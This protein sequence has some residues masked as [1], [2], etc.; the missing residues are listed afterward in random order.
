MTMGDI[1]REKRRALGLTQEQVAEHLGISTPAVNKWERGA[2]NPDLA[3]LPALARLLK[4]D[5][6][7]LFDFRE[8]P[9]EAE[10]EDFLAD[11]GEVV[12]RDGVEAAFALAEQKLQEYPCCDKL[13]HHAAMLLGGALLLSGLPP[14][15]QE[16]YKRRLVEFYEQMA[17]SGE[18]AVRVSGCYMLASEYLQREDY[19]KAQAMID[20]LPEPS[21][22]DKRTFQADLLAKQG[23][24]DEAAEL[25]E[26][27]FLGTLN[28]LQ[29]L[30]LKLIGLELAAGER[31]RAAD[32]V[33]IAQKAAAVFD[34][35]PYCAVVP[36]L[37]LT[38]AAQ[39]Q[40]ETL[41]VLRKLLAAVQAPWDLRRSRLFWRIAQEPLGDMA[42][43]MLPP[44][45]T[46]LEH[47]PQF[48][49]LRGSSEFQ[50]LLEQYGAK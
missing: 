22:M 42:A 36:S 8:A 18:E 10:I 24:P 28:E 20:Q 2:S 44:L 49:F 32:I 43:A 39:D 29:M 41:A 26:K 6:N 12:R 21:A 15:A 17:Q 3:L 31:Q 25:V 27:W 1:I 48:D 40:A 9:P 23:K 45:L 37:E 14:Q 46:G 16:P 19:D 34:M 7:A 35:W 11:L 13:L 38:V 30:W 5:L 33:E 50:A 47:D 4:T